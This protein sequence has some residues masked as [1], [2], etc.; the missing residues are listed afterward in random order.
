[1]ITQRQRYILL[2]VIILYHSHHDSEWHNLSWVLIYILEQFLPWMHAD[3]AQFS[4][5]LS[6]LGILTWS[7]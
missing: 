2:I 4:F 7:T 5:S 6:G 3:S 1:M